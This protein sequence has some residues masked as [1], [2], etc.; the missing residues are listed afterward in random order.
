MEA[1]DGRWFQNGKP[2]DHSPRDQA[3]SYLDKLMGRL[4]TQGTSIPAHGIAT[5]VPDTPVDEDAPIQDD[6]RGR[7]LGANHLAWC[8]EALPPLLVNAMG[9]HARP[10][11]RPAITALHALWGE[12]WTPRLSLGQRLRADEADRLHLD[13]KQVELSP[14]G[15]AI[16]ACSSPGDQARARHSRRTARTAAVFQRWS[17]P[18]AGVA[19]GRRRHRGAIDQPAGSGTVPGV[20]PRFCEGTCQDTTY[21]MNAASGG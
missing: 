9:P 2:L 6:L 12:T 7:L 1:R 16:S 19:P 5:C 8:A 20:R 14:V 11:E 15:S 3:R 13:E 21:W 18:V 4:R 10:V 17:G